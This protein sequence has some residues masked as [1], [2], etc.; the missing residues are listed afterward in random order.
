ML[1]LLNESALLASPWAGPYIF[2]I[3][4]AINGVRR[5]MFTLGSGREM[6]K[7]IGLGAAFLL[8][9][10]SPEILH[11]AIA[12]PA[13]KPAPAAQAANANTFV[14][15]CSAGQTVVDT[16]PDPVWIGASFAH[17]DC[18]APAM[19]VTFDGANATREKIVA[20]MAAAKRYNVQAAAYQKCISDFVVARRTAA[21]KAKK[22]MD[23]ALVTIEDHRIAASEN[24][25]K[26]VAA[27]TGNEIQAFN[28]FGSQC[29]D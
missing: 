12:A 24:N 11:V 16:R 17:D 21:D 10:A 25:K 20:A 8:V 23:V 22:V 6:L 2:D 28:E 9:I 7:K 13:P 29:D 19:P 4:A 1:R 26:K 15:T 14:P 5:D 3:N 27:L 18:W